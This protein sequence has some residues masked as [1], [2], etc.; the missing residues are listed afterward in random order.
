LLSSWKA[1]LE[2]NQWLVSAKW[3]VRLQ[4]SLRKKKRKVKMK[5]VPFRIGYAL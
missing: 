2:G 5:A 4:P 1:V 3:K